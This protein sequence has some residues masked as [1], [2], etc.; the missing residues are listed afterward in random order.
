MQIYGIPL[1]VNEYESG[2]NLF[3]LHETPNIRPF[4]VF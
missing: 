4:S 3:F 1:Q 2:K